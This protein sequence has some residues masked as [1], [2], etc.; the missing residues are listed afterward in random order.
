VQWRRTPWHTLRRE[1]SSW[2]AAHRQTPLYSR[3]RAP[4]TSTPATDTFEL[5]GSPGIFHHERVPVSGSRRRIALDKR[6]LRLRRKRSVVTRKPT[7]GAFDHAAARLP[8]ERTL[9]R[10]AERKGDDKRPRPAAA[11][12]LH[13]EHSIIS[14][15]PSWLTAAIRPVFGLPPLRFPSS[16]SASWF[17]C[18]LSSRLLPCRSPLNCC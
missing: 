13:S 16:S 10:H 2:A 4:P 9:R 7:A 8:G 15:C 14:S 18:C 11:R 17:P 12:D 3:A 5:C 6:L 1:P